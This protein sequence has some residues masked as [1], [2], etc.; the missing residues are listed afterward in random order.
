M[1]EIGIMA[2]IRRPYRSGRC[3]PSVLFRSAFADS[4]SDQIAQRSTDKEKKIPAVTMRIGIHSM[5]AVV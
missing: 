2:F 4:S 5:A 1:T 3:L